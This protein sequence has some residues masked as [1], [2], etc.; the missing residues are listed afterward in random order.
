[1]RKLEILTASGRCYAATIDSAT[2][3]YLYSQ[4][5]AENY[6]RS[7]EVTDVNDG[8]YFAI[9]ADLI[10]SIVIWEDNE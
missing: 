9:K 5:V 4:V 1:M 2:A 6:D 3:S 8:A 10:E 7:I